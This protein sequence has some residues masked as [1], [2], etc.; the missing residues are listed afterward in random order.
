MPGGGCRAP[1]VSDAAS[2]M[3]Q[4]ADYARYTAHILRCLSALTEAERPGHHNGNTETMRETTHEHLFDFGNLSPGN[5]ARPRWSGMRLSVIFSCTLPAAL[6][7]CIIGFSLLMSGIM[8]G[9]YVFL[10]GIFWSA[11]CGVTLID[12]F[13]GMD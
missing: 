10:T 7:C 12:I 5:L 1:A 4:E 3:Y 11:A 2:G 13:S 8:Q 9:L 6:L